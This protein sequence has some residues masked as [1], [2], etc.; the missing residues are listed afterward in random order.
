[1]NKILTSA[2]CLFAS[3]IVLAGSANTSITRMTGIGSSTTSAVGTSSVLESAVGTRHLDA[4]TG[5]DTSV[6][7]ESYTRTSA[8]IENYAEISTGTSATSGLIIDATR[9][10]ESTFRSTGTSSTIGSA[11]QARTTAETGTF[12]AYDQVNNSYSSEAG[13]YVSNT[14]DISATNYVNSLS[15]SNYSQSAYSIYGAN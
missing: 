15:T 9:I 11:T 6:R 12:T 14:A 8:T 4:S 13:T 2:I 7:D 10:G 1:M 3:Q 5:L